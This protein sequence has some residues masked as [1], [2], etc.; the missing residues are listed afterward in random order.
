MKADR[1]GR[2]GAKLDDSKKSV[3]LFKYISLTSNEEER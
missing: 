1:R 3:G 2:G